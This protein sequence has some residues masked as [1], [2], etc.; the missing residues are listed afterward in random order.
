MLKRFALN[1]PQIKLIPI[2]K[3]IGNFTVSLPIKL[4]DFLVE[5][6]CIPII[7]RENK[8]KLNI[9]IKRIF[10]NGKNIFFIL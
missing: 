9:K 2:I 4:T 3:L 5:L 10:R 6:F 8:D 1:E 7:N